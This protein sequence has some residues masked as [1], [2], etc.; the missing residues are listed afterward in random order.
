MFM[1][2]I[3]DLSPHRFQRS[4]SAYCGVAVSSW[5]RPCLKLKN[6][7]GIIDQVTGEHEPNKFERLVTSH[8]EFSV[9]SSAVGCD[10]TVT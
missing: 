1:D 3:V 8:E 7:M 2:E 4:A 6:K 10:S 5:F 9:F